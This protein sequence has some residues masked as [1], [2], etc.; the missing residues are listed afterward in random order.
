M[1]LVPMPAA[2]PAPVPAPVPVAAAVVKV[3]D[4][5]EYKGWFKKA[6]MGI[7][8]Q[9]LK[10]VRPIPSIPLRPRLLVHSPLRSR[11][12]CLARAQQKMAIEAPHLD[13]DLLDTPNA[14]SPNQPAP[15]MAAPAAAPMGMPAMPGAAPAMPPM[16]GMPAMPPMPG[17]P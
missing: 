2:A 13:A 10:N 6:G 4:D 14:P 3:C 1:A 17:M 9:A 7:P 15:V 5:P 11:P 16:P 8:I 12:P